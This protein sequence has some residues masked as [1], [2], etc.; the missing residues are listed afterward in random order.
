VKRALFGFLLLCAFCFTAQAQNPLSVLGRVVT[1]SMDARTKAEVTADANI[2]AGAS[3]RLL[4]DKGSEWKGVA[5]LVFAQHV[6]LA[7][8]V[9]NDKV[10]K[11]VEE[12]VRRDKSIRSL[13]NELLT[14]DVGQLAKDTALEAEINATL[15]ATKGISSVNM[16]WS[17]TGGRVVLMGVALSGQEASLAAQKVRNMKGVRSVAS[18]LRVVQQ[19][20]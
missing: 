18:H 7:G 6:V 17:A 1:T 20:K 3:K 15:T 19:K 9:K 5:L 16:R 13:K 10:R 2:S 12:V 14:G 8:A 11:R 4:D